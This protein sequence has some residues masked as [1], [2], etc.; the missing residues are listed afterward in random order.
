MSNTVSGSTAFTMMQRTQ[1]KI[2]RTTLLH[3]LSDK[4]LDKYSKLEI[5]IRYLNELKYEQ[6]TD[7]INETRQI[8]PLLLQEFQEKEQ[9]LP[10]VKFFDIAAKKSKERYSHPEHLKAF[11]S[12]IEDL[13]INMLFRDDNKE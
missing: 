7:Y 9:F 2:S 3:N 8:L 4:T 12:G 11:R 10:W 5:V 13:V 1:S 6:A